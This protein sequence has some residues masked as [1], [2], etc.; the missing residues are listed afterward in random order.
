MVFSEQKGTFRPKHALQKAIVVENNLPVKLILG[1][2]KMS[3]S[4]TPAIGSVLVDYNLE[5]TTESHCYLKFDN[6][7]LDFITQS[8]PFKKIESDLIR[9]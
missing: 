1:L 4:N 3:Q 6:N 2:Y 9:D 5:Y 7:S 8:R